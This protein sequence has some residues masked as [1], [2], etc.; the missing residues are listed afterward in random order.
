[1]N[2]PLGRAV[3]NVTLP[4]IT[5]RRR[6][7]RGDLRDLRRKNPGATIGPTGQLMDGVSH[8]LPSLDEP[9]SPWGRSQVEHQPL[10]YLGRRAP[11]PLVHG[12]CAARGHCPSNGVINEHTFPSSPCG[13]WI[14][15]NPAS[16]VLLAGVFCCSAQRERR[17]RAGSAS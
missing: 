4:R 6:H 3:T 7:R 9:R 1:M 10:F 13:G 2:P 17:A 11:V 15:G 5:G 14:G 12:G 16:W 8:E